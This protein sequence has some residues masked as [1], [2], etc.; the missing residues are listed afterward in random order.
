MKIT[1][2]DI[3]H[4]A[5]NRVRGNWTI[6]QVRTDEGL[7]GL[8]EATN[9]YAPERSE[10]A[11]RRLEPLIVGRDPLNIEAF[12]Q[13]FLRPEHLAVPHHGHFCISP[14]KGT[15]RGFDESF[16]PDPHLGLLPED[17]LHVDC[18]QRPIEGVT[19]GE[20]DTLPGERRDSKR[21]YFEI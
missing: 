16:V 12:V 10:Q 15:L 8:G 1:G 9:V 7:T 13:E 11:L 19:S 3:T 17:F 14:R 18:F 2:I 20:I 5:V 6:V 21:R 4:V